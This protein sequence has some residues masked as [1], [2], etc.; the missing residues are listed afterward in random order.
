MQRVSNEKKNKEECLLGLYLDG[1]KV[2]WPKGGGQRRVEEVGSKLC[3]F[4]C[5]QKDLGKF[6]PLT[7]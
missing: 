4:G 6:H 5:K 1:E 3:L 7:T 2:L